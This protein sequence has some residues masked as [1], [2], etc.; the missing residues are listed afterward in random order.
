MTSSDLFSFVMSCAAT[1]TLLLLAVYGW[2]RRRET[3]A[4]PFTAEIIASAAWGICLIM[5]MISPDPT[6]ALFW[7]RLRFMGSAFVPVFYLLRVLE[8]VDVRI[9]HQPRRYWFLFIIPAVTN[10]IVWSDRAFDWFFLNWSVERQGL[11]YIEISSFQG[12]A[13][14]PVLYSYLLLGLGFLFIG[15]EIRRTTGGFRQQAYLIFL[16]AFVPSA[17][18]F[19]Y[20]IF[21][22]DL[23]LFRQTPTLLAASA[24]INTWALLG[25]NLLHVVPVAHST[26]LDS[27]DV[28]VLVLDKQD[29]VVSLNATA[30]RFATLKAAENQPVDQV[31]P[32]FSKIIQQYSRKY[33][34]RDEF[35][36]GED[37]QKQY[38][39]VHITPLYRSVGRLAGRVAMVRDIT[40]RKQIEE[41]LR[42]LDRAVNHSPVGMLIVV[43]EPGQP[44]TY[45][46]DT[47]V[48]ITGYTREEFIGRDVRFLQRED[49]DQ[50]GLVDLRSALTEG[51]PTR[52]LVRA[53][54]K[55]GSLFWNEV[56]LAP[57][58]DEKNRTTHFVTTQMDVSER[59]AAEEQEAKLIEKIAS[60]NRELKDF[61]YVV[62][63][64][65][66][67]PLRGV[68]SIAH[69]LVEEYADKF[70]AEGKELVHLL[71]GR[72]RRM[73]QMINGVLE[74]ARI[75]HEQMTH[76]EVDLN[77]LVEQ[78]VQDI[79][80]VDRIEVVIENTLPTLHIDPVRIRQVFQNLIDN[81]V[82]YMDK[83]H[84]EIRIGAQRQA[85][86]W[87]FWV[88][89]NGVGIAAEHH[90]RI[91]QMFQTLASTDQVESTGIGLPLVKRIVELYNGRVW[92]TSPPAGGSS[93]QF[94]LPAAL[95]DG[96][97]QPA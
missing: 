55:D 64:D 44:A 61:A 5:Q 93:F 62:S 11:F 29:R 81:A 54:R 14:V 31:F 58:V 71:I 19:L 40:G 10:L 66:R 12:W 46:N 92:V 63:H 23:N 20:A 4:S 42:L 8:Y 50:S 39:E 2:R 36:L 53:Y 35:I 28:G 87:R 38:F 80:P 68:N 59:V 7:T 27:L 74:Y 22:V 96:Q 24:L 73:E 47:F 9:W 16:A 13:P 65:L 3:A 67:A 48:S 21:G 41:Q 56:W 86:E 88:Q 17:V 60:T 18:H 43:N 69:W 78:V 49:R 79:V 84:G 97:D 6:S 76:D 51:R 95:A 15:R 52:T 26:I 90:E 32:A 75:G 85:G 34:V 82:K 89:D 72:V 1:T 70:D 37:L 45:V 91:F 30:K 33:E 94:T 83:P 77:A 25:G 57:V